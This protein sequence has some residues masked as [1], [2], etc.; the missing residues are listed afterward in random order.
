MCRFF[1]DWVNERIMVLK[2]KLVLA[3]KSPRRAALLK[4][5]GLRFTTKGSSVRERRNGV[6]SPEQIVLNLSR[7]KAFEVA[8]KVRSGII[9]GVD[10]VVVLNGKIYGKPQKASEAKAMLKD[11]SGNE[12]EVY[13]GFTLIDRPSN[14]SV[15]D[16]EVTRVKFRELSEE[17]IEEYVRSGSPLDKAGAYGIQDDYGAVFVER[18]SGSFYNVV[19]LPVEKFYQRLKEFQKQIPS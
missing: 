16:F 11:L 4:Q 6:M 8:K 3:S 15:S 13:T 14:K 1:F 9:I 10:T 2:K 12:H 18:I 19:G 17:E 7:K 5:I